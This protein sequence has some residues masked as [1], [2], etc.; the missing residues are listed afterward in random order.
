LCTIV[1]ENVTGKFEG[2][3][4]CTEIKVSIDAYAD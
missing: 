4:L 3:Y 1:F 2:L